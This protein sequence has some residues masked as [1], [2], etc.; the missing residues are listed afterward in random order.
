MVNGKLYTLS[1]HHKVVFA[2]NPVN[3][4]DERTLAP[5]FERHGNAVLFTPLPPA[6]IYEK[7]LKPVF[8]NVGIELEPIAQRILDVYRFVCECSTTEILIS[9]RELQMMALMTIAN[10]D[11]YG[12]DINA[13]AEH[14][15]YTLARNLVPESKRAGFDAKFTPKNPIVFAP[16]AKPDRTFFVTESRLAL[17]QQFDDLLGLREWRRIDAASLNTAQKGGGLGGMIVEGAP[18]IGKSE[19]VIAALRARGYQEEHDFTQPTAKE[20]PFYR[21]PVSMP[22]SEKEALLIKAFHEG[23]VVMID[24]INSSPMMERLLNNLLMGKNPKGQSGDVVKPGFMIIA[25][26]NPVTMAGRRA[27]STA[28]LRRCITHQLPEYKPEEIQHTLVSKG[29]SLEEAQAMTEAYEKNRIY[30]VKHQ[31]SPAPNFRH[32]IELADNQ[33]KAKTVPTPV[34]PGIMQH[35][36]FKPD[37]ESKL[38]PL[39]H[40]P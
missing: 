39:E 20:N 5:F 7:I 23:A 21:M 16:D 13:I 12:S 15:T 11:K 4:G 24:E 36:I 33:L 14:F 19:L 32:L 38:Q 31:L 8:E 18:G 40:K 28:I 9:P 6:V 25:T 26:Q 22:L 35:S 34:R 2:G 1:T 3:Y 17:S 10:A 29:I 27:P 30:A 37:L